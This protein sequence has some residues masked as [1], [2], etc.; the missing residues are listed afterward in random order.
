MLKE[1]CQIQNHQ[2]KQ[3]TP[4]IA[5]SIRSSPVLMRCVVSCPAILFKHMGLSLLWIALL[6]GL[7]NDFKGKPLKLS[8]IFPNLVDLLLDCFVFSY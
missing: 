5:V 3:M 8:P 4:L 1:K 2:A 7:A 6:R